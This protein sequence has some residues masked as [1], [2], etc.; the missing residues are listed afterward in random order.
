MIGPARKFLAL[1]DPEE[2]WR[3]WALAASMAVSG[4][5]Q[6]IG[7]ASIIPF[8]AVVSNP[9]VITENRYLAWGYEY[10]G[11]T[12][13]REYLLA[14]GALF[15]AITVVSNGFAAFTAWLTIRVRW[16]S[17]YRIS[18]RLLEQYLAAP[19]A[20]HLTQNSAGIFKILFGHVSKAVGE[21]FVP[22]CRIFSRLVS[23]AFIVALL[24]WADP[25]LA[26]LVPLTIGGIYALTY[27]AVH[28]QQRQAGLEE[29][30]TATE[31]FQTASEAFGGIKDIKVL[32]REAFFLDRFRLSAQRF[33]SAYARSEAISQLPRFG[34]DAIAYSG[35][36][37]VILYLLQTRQSLDEIFPLIAVYA[38][39]ANRLIPGVQEVFT[40][41]AQIRFNSPALDEIYE[42]AQRLKGWRFDRVASDDRGL[43]RLT[44]GLKPSQYIRI[45]D[46]SFTYV[47]SH[48]P[49]LDGINLQIP[50]R[51]TSAF[52]GETG[53]GKTTLADIVLGL[54]E[55]TK[56]RVLIDDTV[57][58][59][60]VMPRWRRSVGYVPQQIFLA[61]TSIAR[62][63]AYGI[64]EEDVDQNAVHAAA[65]A[66]HLD[67][68]AAS[69]PERYDT[70]VGE[71]GVRLSGGQRQRIG[72]ARA[73]YHNPDVL[74]FD[75][76]TSA[77]DTVT[78][79]IVMQAINE[80]AGS[81]TI[82]LIA[83]RLSTVRSCDTIFVL[84]GGRLVGQGRYEELVATNATFRAM[85]ST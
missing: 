3:L 7:I 17:Y 64:A 71:R 38:L 54:F 58:D 52:V 23:S 79:E 81:R 44:D 66:A 51:R 83:H 19:Y 57:L 39:G 46:L 35:V 26:A 27:M 62:N 85:A 65:K 45:E 70:F 50:V 29:A 49:A 36:V 72:I 9:T 69:L 37:A 42:D 75:E 59:K 55:P 21:V 43:A 18:Q 10:F 73:L 14:L 61:D 11:F 34:L 74:V 40:S 48:R 4:I 6:T 16:R 25:L 31:R 82:I 41:L 67:E 84:D 56:G 13:T 2:Y 20:F 28:K 47:G 24:I 53:S 33:A 78:E 22:M 80:L 68:F 15:I 76:A 63:I 77:L 32:G 30:R 12:D 60:T 5:L 1:Y 8:L